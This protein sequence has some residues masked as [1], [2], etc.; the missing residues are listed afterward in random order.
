MANVVERVDALSQGDRRI[1]VIDKG[2]KLAF[3]CQYVYV[4]SI[5]GLCVAL[6]AQLETFFADGIT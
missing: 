5:C 1:I 3:R 4:H 6:R 2:D